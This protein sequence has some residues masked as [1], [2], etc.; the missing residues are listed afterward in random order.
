[1]P[2]RRGG[3]LHGL[4]WKFHMGQVC[5]NAGKNDAVAVQN[6][7]EIKNVGLLQN[8]ALRVFD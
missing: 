8:N 3:F 5:K 7:F 2:R 1:M 4:N 6:A